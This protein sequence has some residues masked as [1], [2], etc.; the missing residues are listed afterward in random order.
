MVGAEEASCNIGDEVCMAWRIDCCG[1]G[2]LVTKLSRC[3]VRLGNRIS[4]RAHTRFD[5]CLDGILEGTNG[6]DN[7][8][9][10]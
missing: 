4:Q 10:A 2:S 6:S 1:I 9:L 5:E 3:A 7:P 8:R